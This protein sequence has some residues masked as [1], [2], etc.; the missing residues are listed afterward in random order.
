MTWRCAIIVMLISASPAFAVE[1][2]QVPVTITNSGTAP[3]ACTAQLAHWYSTEL[4][5]AAPGARLRIALW[6]EGASGTYVMLNGAH[7]NMP[8]EALWCGI[9]GRAYETRATIQLNRSDL[10]CAPS[11]ERLVCN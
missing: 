2:R 5:T 7:E 9:K 10:A 4:G 11:S 3:I 8:V 1:L 6:L